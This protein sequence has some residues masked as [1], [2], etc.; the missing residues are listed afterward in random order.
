MDL[1]VL[2]LKK[3]IAVLLRDAAIKLV[4]IVVSRHSALII[5]S[6]LTVL[7]TIVIVDLRVVLL[8]EITEVYKSRRANVALD[9]DVDALSGMDIP[10][11]GGLVLALVDIRLDD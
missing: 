5:V 9:L 3:C 11:V 1:A 7:I 8:K 6:G 10:I 2:M 4:L